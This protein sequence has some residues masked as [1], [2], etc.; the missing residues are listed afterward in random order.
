MK[1]DMTQE[2]FLIKLADRTQNLQDLADLT[3]LPDGFDLEK[4]YQK[5]DEGQQMLDALEHRRHDCNHA[6]FK[7][8]TKLLK[9]AVDQILDQRR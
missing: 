8:I 1:N 2:A 7:L 9:R 4:V 3:N 5:A 6:Q